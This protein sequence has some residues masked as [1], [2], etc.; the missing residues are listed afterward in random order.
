MIM[1]ETA[2]EAASLARLRLDGATLEDSFVIHI[3]QLVCLISTI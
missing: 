2:R 1:E 3:L